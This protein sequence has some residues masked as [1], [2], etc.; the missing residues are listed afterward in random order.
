V[1]TGIGRTA[2]VITPARPLGQAKVDGV[3]WEAS[4]VGGAPV[5]AL[6]RVTRN[7]GLTLEAMRSRT[8]ATTRIEPTTL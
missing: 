6:V 4:R 8:E 3:I 7:D 5:G 2:E 1:Q